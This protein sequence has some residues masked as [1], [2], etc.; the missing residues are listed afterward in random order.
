[1]VLRMMFAEVWTLGS[2]THVGYVGR[3]LKRLRNL[4]LRVDAQTDNRIRISRL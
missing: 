1:M 3:K 2:V 4:Y